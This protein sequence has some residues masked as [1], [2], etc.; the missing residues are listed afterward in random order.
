MERGSD[1][2]KIPLVNIRPDTTLLLVGVLATAAVPFAAWGIL[3]VIA[4]IWKVNLRATLTWLHALRWIVWL[5]GMPLI[6]TAVASHR[7]F[8]LF[9]I[10]MSL[11]SASILFEPVEGW[12]KKRYAPELVVP[13]SDGWWPTLRK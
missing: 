8:W 9:P 6:L 10:G 12:V 3:G 4:R 7:Y 13:E 2:R 11:T 1:W 5:T